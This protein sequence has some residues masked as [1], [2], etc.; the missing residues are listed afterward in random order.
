MKDGVPRASRFTLHTSRWL[1][2]VGLASY[3]AV[4]SYV[5]WRRLGE[6]MASFHAPSLVAMAA[7]YVAAVWARAAKWRLVLGADRQ[8]VG[9]YFVSKAGGGLSPGRVGELAPLLL[10]GHRDARLAAWII[11]DRLLEGGSTILLGIAG[12]LLL[13]VAAART[14]WVFVGA[15]VVLV[16]APMILLQSGPSSQR[17]PKRSRARPWRIAH[18]V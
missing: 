13:K 17:R 7:V 18:C 8:A 4:V 6:V 9:L 2:I 5:G 3:M 16:V 12:V 1:W 10:P 15:L 14:I 11:L